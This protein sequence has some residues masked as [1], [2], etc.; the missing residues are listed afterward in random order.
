MNCRICNRN[1]FR[2][3]YKGP[4][5]D[6]GIKAKFIDGYKVIECLGCS[7]V[8]L[9]PIPEQIDKFYESHEYRSR[10][11]NEFK[12]ADIH[13]KYDHEQNERINRIGI[14]NIRNKTIIDL[15]AS[16]G[17]FLDSTLGIA[18]ETIAIEPMSLYKK[19]LLSKGHK[20]FSYPE[21]AIKSKI[22]ADIVTSFD[23]I[24]HIEYP[25][26]F[27]K[28]AYKL[29]KPGGVFILSMPNYNDLLLS[30]AKE[31]FTPFFFQTAHLNYF[32]KSCVR[33][34]Y[35]NSKFDE[36]KIDYLHKYNLDNLLG[37]VKFGKPG[38]SSLFENIFDRFSNNAFRNTLERQGIASHLFIKL[39]KCK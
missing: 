37:W 20:H 18:K 8:Q 7:L 2:I 27:F 26:K 21:E 24:E 17:V 22:K 32:D 16:A 19:Y 1:K 15:G 14:Q 10:W 9:Y 3:I 34:M 31:R 33:N 25:M 30:F 5:R 23:V 29:L 39:Y 11:D 36:I 13:K 12:P 6:G 4:I 38:K 28:N 35:K